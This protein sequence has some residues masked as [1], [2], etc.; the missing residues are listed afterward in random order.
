[1]D[2]DYV[3]SVFE[4]YS[5]QGSQDDDKPQN[6]VTKGNA[7]LAYEEIFKMWKVDLDLQQEKTLKDVYF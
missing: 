3:Q 4:T 1:L 7:I 2:K 5:V 6:L